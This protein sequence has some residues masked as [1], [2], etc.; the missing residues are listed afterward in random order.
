MS[1]ARWGWDGAWYIFWQSTDAESREAE[2]LAL[3][4]CRVEKR[5][6]PSYSYA[7]I[8]EFLRSKDFSRIPWYN[9]KEKEESFLRDCMRSFLRDVDR[10][11]GKTPE[12]EFIATLNKVYE[13]PVLQIEGNKITDFIAVDKDGQRY[14]LFEEEDGFVYIAEEPQLEKLLDGYRDVLARTQ[15]ALEELAGL[16][17]PQV[18]EHIEW[19]VDPFRDMFTADEEVV[20]KE[21]KNT[22]MRKKPKRR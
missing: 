2:Q 15:V 9:P 5:A 16:V 4:C 20:K 6:Y 8:K 14:L 11:W 1:Y 13:F 12:E 22:T 3:W 18:E 21:T 10:E 17:L 7:E 19:K